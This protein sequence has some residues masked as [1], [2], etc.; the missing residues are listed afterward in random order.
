[1]LS[2]MEADIGNQRK[3]VCSGAFEWFIVK[4]VIVISTTAYI[5]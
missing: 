2:G 3:E 1:M 4:L 5:E